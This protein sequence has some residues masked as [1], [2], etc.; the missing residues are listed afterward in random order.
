MPPDLG[1]L[2]RLAVAVFVIVMPTLMFLGL[3]RLLNRMR[4]EDLIY[5]L[6]TDEEL[7]SVERSHSLAGFVEEVTGTT[8]GAIRCPDCGGLNA[9]GMDSCVECGARIG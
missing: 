2:A 4:D 9:A 3:V 5:R 6:M 8:P 1:L 7:R